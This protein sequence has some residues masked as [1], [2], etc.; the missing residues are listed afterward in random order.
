MEHY[1]S[2]RVPVGG[3]SANGRCVAPAATCCV[4]E[5]WKLVQERIGNRPGLPCG[6]GAGARRARL[7]LVQERIGLIDRH[8]RKGQKLE[9]RPGLP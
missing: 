9:C 4:S 3:G 1:R 6:Q 8:L 7:Q 2:V 5:G